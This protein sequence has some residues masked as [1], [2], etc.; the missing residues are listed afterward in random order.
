MLFKKAIL[1]ADSFYALLATPIEFQLTV[2]AYGTDLL[3][4]EIIGD[5]YP[6][7]TSVA[8]TKLIFNWEAWIRF[9]LLP[10]ENI[11]PGTYTLIFSKDQLLVTD[12]VDVYTLH[13]R[14][15]EV[16]LIDVPEEEDGI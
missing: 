10:E 3:A 12:D 4:A 14:P 13:D 6:Y 15:V 1:Y 9:H 7:E 16:V 11:P 5:G 8:F 2:K